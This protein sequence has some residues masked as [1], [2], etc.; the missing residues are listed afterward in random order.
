MMLNEKAIEG[1]MKAPPEKRY[2]SFLNTVADLEEVWFLSSKDGFATF[3][4]NDVKYV[5]IWPREEFCKYL[6]SEGE[7]PSSME[8]HE[9]LKKCVNLKASVRFMVFP[10]KLD[11]FV[12][13]AEKL[14]MDIRACL[15]EVE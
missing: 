6:I 3:D 2:K 11:S 12:T 5:L 14:C 13:T 15:D 1:I 8:I 9:F 10:T 7:K 4:A